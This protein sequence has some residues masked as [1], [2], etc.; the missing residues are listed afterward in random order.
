[1]ELL[2]PAPGLLSQLVRG[3]RAL[4]RAEALTKTIAGS[5][6]PEAA[7]RALRSVLLRGAELARTATAGGCAPG[8]RASGAQALGQG[9]GHGRVIPEVVRLGASR[10]QRV[11]HEPASLATSPSRSPGPCRVDS[12]RYE[13]AC[14]ARRVSPPAAPRGR[15]VSS[16]RAATPLARQVPQRRMTAR[17]GG[18]RAST[19]RAGLRE[20]FAKRRRQAVE[21]NEAPRRLRAEVLR[22]FVQA[23]APRRSCRSRGQPRA[24]GRGSRGLRTGRLT[25][26]RWPSRASWRAR[27][28]ASYEVSFRYRPMT[29]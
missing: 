6:P 15:A 10:P 4:E 7:A 14:K 11:A 21:W 2:G 20:A 5:S 9:P 22:V 26:V 12:A 29:Q 23:G 13:R 24:R 3:V 8:R 18:R 27:P 16:R 28:V 17:A 19:P 25:S 1:M